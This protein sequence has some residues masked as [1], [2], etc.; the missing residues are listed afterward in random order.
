MWPVKDMKE[1]K[2][3]CIPVHKY[4]I[5]F[6]ELGFDDFLYVIT[7]LELLRMF[8]FIDDYCRFYS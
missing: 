8:R 5:V 3:Q 1:T 6:N 4:V 7:F 2:F